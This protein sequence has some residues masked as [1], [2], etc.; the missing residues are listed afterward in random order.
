MKTIIGAGVLSLPYTIS[1]LG[2]ILAI[3][4]FV[5][6]MSLSYFSTTLLVAAKNISRHSN[7]S[8]IFFFLHNNKPIKALGSIFIVLKNVGICIAPLLRHCLTYHL[9]RVHQKNTR[10]PP[11]RNLKSTYPL[12]VVHSGRVYHCNHRPPIVSTCNR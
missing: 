5:L 1:K 12:I 11:Y 6:V 2:Y 3:I 7:F 8:T 9:Q 4:I 10:R